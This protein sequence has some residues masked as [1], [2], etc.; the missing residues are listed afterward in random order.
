MGNFYFM[1]VQDIKV[2]YNPN[3]MFHKWKEIHQRV[4]VPDQN[5]EFCFLCYFYNKGKS[6][7]QV[8]LLSVKVLGQ[9]FLWH[10]NGWLMALDIEFST[11][12][13]TKQIAVKWKCGYWLRDL[14]MWFLP[15]HGYSKPVT[16]VCA[17]PCR[18]SAQKI[19]Q[20]LI[21]TT[22]APATALPWLWDV[23]SASFCL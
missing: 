17:S 7:S 8:G 5:I 22:R 1:E 10:L 19:G 9:S 16:T 6:G 21:P 3:F 23:C 11:C 14:S 20:R 2:S 4:S 12:V 13:W 18:D 15:N